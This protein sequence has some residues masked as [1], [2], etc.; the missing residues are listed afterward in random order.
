MTQLAAKH[1]GLP[2]R[3]VVRDGAPADLVLSDPARIVDRATPEEPHRTASG[4]H[5]VW[6]NGVAAYAG[7]TTTGRRPGLGLRRPSGGS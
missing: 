4:I 1:V 3:G 7:G 2:E 5:T 6:V